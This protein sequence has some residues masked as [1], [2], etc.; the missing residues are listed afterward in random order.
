MKPGIAFPDYIRTEKTRRKKSLFSGRIYEQRILFI[1]V[2]LAIALII[3]FSRLFFL[4]VIKG[5]YYRSLSDENRTRTSIIHA[6]RG[7]IFDTN[8]KPLVFNVPGFREIV[9]GKTRVIDNTKALSLIAQ[10]KKDLEIDQL[11]S[12]PYGEIVAH[13]L[14]YIGQISE[15]E[16]K[17]EEFMDY[18]MGDLIGKAGIEQEYDRLL[19]GI[20]GKILTEVD[21]ASKTVRKLGQTDPIPG[22]NITV[23]LDTDLQ[24][25][26]FSAMQ[27]V[28]KGAAIVSTP[29]GE[30]L[31]FVSKPSFDPNLFTLPD[32]YE[33]AS[34]SAYKNVYEIL[35]DGDSQPLINRGIQG[36][37]PPGSTFKIVV[38]AAGLENKIIDE[39]FEVEDTGVL[40]VGQF[41]FANWY[42][43]Q[44][45]R[46]EGSVNL[47]KGLARSNDI[48]FYRLAEKI[49]VDRISSM[50]DKFG[51]GD[52]TGIDLEGEF[53]G[54]VPSPSWKEK[55]I[56]ERWYL[57]DTYHYGIG[58]GYLLATPL[59]VNIWTAAIAN[60]GVLSTPHLLKN[61][62]LK[63]KNEKF[64]SEKTIGLIRQ[65][66]VESC[67]PGGV[68]WPLFEFRIKNSELRIDGKN[69]MEI[70]VSSGSADMR[71]VSIACKTGTAEVGGEDELP[72]ASITLFAPAYD[73]QIVVTILAENSGE[74]SNIAAPIA[75]KILEAYFE[76]K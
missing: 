67:S 52:T 49:G 66:M 43:T 30:I 15:E 14:G 38:A 54:L 41:S 4:Q 63:I 23:T 22:E 42:Y 34:E 6:A 73:P 32:S 64:L 65:G 9:E 11:R 1:P 28:N 18:K 69:F 74:G 35:L 3:L 46:K 8:G 24:K 71:E 76:N 5:S 10:G 17:K 39:N 19:K 60:N 56:G 13:V 59:Q 70:P 12:Y 27:D 37:Y 2:V 7:I 31:A 48:F 45:G 33:T 55:A 75:K 50:A 58:Q 16:L 62:K 68:A 53:A 47:V 20:D 57:G 21:S 61:E 25:S 29:N 40:T 44:Y 36:T 51:L 26:V 72:H